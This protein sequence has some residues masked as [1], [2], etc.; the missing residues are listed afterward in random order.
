MSGRGKRLWQSRLSQEA[1]VNE[2]SAFLAR[3]RDH[4][5]PLSADSAHL[6][7]VYRA[8]G[9]WPALV[10]QD[11]SR[12]L[13]FGF[14][15][16][17]AMDRIKVSVARL[18][19]VLVKAHFFLAPQALVSQEP[20]IFAA[21]DLAHPGIQRV[22]V[23]YPLDVPAPG[24]A[25]RQRALVAAEW[26]IQHSASRRP[27]LGRS[28]EFPAILKQDSSTW[29]DMPRWQVLRRRAG[30]LPWFEPSFHAGYKALM[31]KVAAC[32]DRASFPYGTVLDYGID[33]K[34]Y[35]KDC[36]ARYAAGLK[37]WFLPH[38]FDVDAV[39]SYL[40]FVSGLS[41]EERLA[42]DWL[43]PRQ[44]PGQKSYRPSQAAH[45]SPVS[46]N[47]SSHPAD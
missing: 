21:P 46:G 37:R 44:P 1:A 39:I 9:V 2:V 25:T 45:A 24:G 32:T 12:I 19:S 28:D 17:P 4:R 13:S 7:H 16:D 41:S 47:M 18:M 22:G 8:D 31:E 35:V 40:D 14:A 27:R 20:F 34:D 23:V 15:A 6:F 42:R 5:L 11:I 29:L 36:G 26:D 43:E 10:G 30:D 33:M 3:C 38:G